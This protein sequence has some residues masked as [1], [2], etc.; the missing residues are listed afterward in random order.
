MKVKHG[1]Y[2]TNDIE[3]SR[4]EVLSIREFGVMAKILKSIDL[5][6]CVS[7]N[8][9]INFKCQCHSSPNLFCNIH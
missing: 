3:G 8:I 4:S 7:I 6:L 9:L 1:Y 2:Q 5:I